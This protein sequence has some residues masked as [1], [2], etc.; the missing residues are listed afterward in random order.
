LACAGNFDPNES[1]LLSAIRIEA[2]RQVLPAGKG[3]I[4]LGTEIIEVDPVV[5]S[6]RSRSEALSNRVSEIAANGIDRIEY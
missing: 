6:V 4:S 2:P 1:C 5:L 3:S